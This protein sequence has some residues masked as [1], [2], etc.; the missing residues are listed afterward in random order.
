[1]HQLYVFGSNGEGQLGI[2]AADIVSIPT[3]SGSWPQDKDIQSVTSGDNHTLILSSDGTTHH[4]GNTEKGQLGTVEV[5]TARYEHFIKSSRTGVLLCAATCESSSYITSST[6]KPTILT[7]GASH[8]GES[9][10]AEP[11][12]LPH[13]VIDFAAGGWHYVVVL[14]NGDVMGWGKSRLDQLGPKLT[15]YQRIKKPTL[16]EEG[17]SFKP[18]KAVCGKE[19]TYLA[20]HPSSGEHYLFGRD[21]Y[22]LKSSMP[23]HIK[24]WKQI[25]ATWN[26]IF[27]L[28]EDGTLTA[29]GKDNM[30][31]LLPDDLP[32]LERMAVGSEHILA[33]TIDRKLISWGWGKHGN[34]GDLTRLGSKV[35]HEMVS[36]LWNE[37][38]IPGNIK[39]IGAGNCTSFVL[40]DLPER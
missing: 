33:L 7:E 21:K 18:I 19:F 17:L 40:T 31:K 37:I 2:A 35:K 16:I 23:A 30:W 27:V 1:M 34:C 5:Q 12:V 39:F 15:A 4:V 10:S 26:A 13:T 28:F 20:S 8:W 11:L 6:D 14:D 36:G 29:W 22:G 9:S 38:E 24:G 3:I 25:G 32:L